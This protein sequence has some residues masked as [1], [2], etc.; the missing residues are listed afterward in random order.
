M[1]FR[2]TEEQRLKEQIFK[3]AQEMAQQ[4]FEKEIAFKS[5]QASDLNYTIIQDL[6]KAA[7][8]TGL[9][10]IKFKDGTEVK[11]ES[12]DDRTQLNQISENLF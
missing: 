12:K 11:I 5:L 1:F 3:R 6:I 8:L 7:R 9:V 4:T 2:K 10:T